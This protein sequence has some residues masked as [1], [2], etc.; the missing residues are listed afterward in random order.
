MKRRV[1]IESQKTK[2]KTSINSKI[3][4]PITDPYEISGYEEAVINKMNKLNNLNNKFNVLPDHEVKVMVNMSR[5]EAERV[6]EVVNGLKRE[7]CMRYMA[8]A[9][10][11]YPDKWY[12]QYNFDRTRD[13]SIFKNIAN[14]YDILRK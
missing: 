5:V 1:I 10:K 3:K 6:L 7:V 14:A 11:Y 13:E 12:E 8:L 9:R 2:F 4:R